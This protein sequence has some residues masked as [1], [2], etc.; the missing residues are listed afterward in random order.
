[1]TFFQALAQRPQRL[2]IRRLNFQVHL[3]VGITLAA[4][5]IVIGVTGSILVFQ[6]ELEDISGLHPW[7]QTR[8]K[9]PVADITLVIA[10]LRAAYPHF[11]ILSINT[12]SQIDP[13][14]VTVLQ[15]RGRIKVASSAVNGEVLGEFPR[16]ATWIDIVRDLHETLLIRRNGRIA[17]GVGA[18]FL[19][20]L[21]AT[22]LVIWW[23]GVRNWKRALKVDFHRNW[24]RINYDTHSAAGFWTLLL[25]SF[26]A[27]SGIYF[28]WPRQVF[29]LVNSLS[30][31][32][33]ARP[34]VMRVIPDPDTTRP[35]LAAM[36][37]RA[38]AVDPG[39]KLSGITFPYGPRAPLE[40]R[41]SRGTGT[42]REYE[43]TVYFSPYTGEY[44]GTWRYGVNQSLGDWIIWS[45]EPLHFGTSWGLGV[46]LIWA[47]AGLSVPLLTITGLL[48]YWNRALRRKWRHLRKSHGALRETLPATAARAI[49]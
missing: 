42:G 49:S 5:L 16:R 4:Y 22:G 32:V 12:P 7:R 14:F 11:R 27:L 48:M 30:P 37:G 18:A 46:K 35:D 19:L 3:W 1:M 31:I 9:G 40:V 20:L 25:V 13:D 26:W 15:G 41:M 34:P 39:T 33:T 29:R 6:P 21:S 17:N 38:S 36:V 8:A 44:L 10:R 23:P 45:Q 2:W 28:A 43:D 47:A 24:R